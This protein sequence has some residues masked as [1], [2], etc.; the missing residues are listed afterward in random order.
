MFLTKKD[1][2]ERQIELLGRTLA[3]L[4]FGKK[5][6]GIFKNLEETPTVTESELNIF[7]M[8]LDNCIKEARVKE[9][10][11]SLKD[12]NEKS[13]KHF[14]LST[15]FYDKVK[16]M[17][18]ADLIKNGLSREEINTEIKLFQKLYS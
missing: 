17:S 6:E 11:L 12:M 14:I 4:L 15:L 8:Y 10:L 7:N 2:V 1:W 5:L 9:V 18:D 3:R 16:E 13:A